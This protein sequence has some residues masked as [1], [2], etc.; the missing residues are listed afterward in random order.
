VLIVGDPDQGRAVGN[1]RMLAFTAKG[2]LGIEFFGLSGKDSP[3]SA[4]PANVSP[5][6]FTE[7]PLPCRNSKF[8]FSHWPWLDW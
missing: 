3:A 1:E 7:E 2:D 4:A 8:G 5:H 6:P